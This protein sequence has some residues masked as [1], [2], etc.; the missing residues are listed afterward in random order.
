MCNFIAKIIDLNE[1]QR[2][3]KKY[4]L[5]ICLSSKFSVN[6]SFVD[7]TLLV[8]LRLLRILRRNVINLQD[9]TA[10]PI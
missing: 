5:L 6:L 7:R 1:N 8:D 2:K 9:I 3:Y 10:A 4:Y